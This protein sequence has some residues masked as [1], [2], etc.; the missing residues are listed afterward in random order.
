MY[1]PVCNTILS[2]H[3]CIDETYYFCWGLRAEA[4][5]N[6]T[7]ILILKKYTWNCPVCLV[8]SG[9][10]CYN[11]SSVCTKLDI[12]VSLT[13]GADLVIVSP[14]AVDIASSA[15][16]GG[17]LLFQLFSHKFQYSHTSTLLCIPCPTLSSKPNMLT[18]LNILA[19]IFFSSYCSS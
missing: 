10:H 16:T 19:I 9:R 4:S 3:W 5:K 8:H 13:S 12:S 14:P 7:G 2:Q 15:F 18:V 17:K 1:P 11:S 6:K